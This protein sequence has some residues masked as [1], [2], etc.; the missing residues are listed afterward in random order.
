MYYGYREPAKSIPSHRM[1]AIRR[2]EKKNILYFDIE[3]EPARA[4]AL[5]KPQVHK[6]P[7][8]WTPQLE[9]AC[10]D[11]WKRLLQVFRDN[12]QNLLLAPPAGAIAVLGIDPGIR[13][14]CKI[15]VGRDRQVSCP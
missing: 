5:I 15:A 10:E 3:L 14:G 6:Q 1:L 4:L 9:L 12:L 8:D 2:G 7:G 13:T 11:A